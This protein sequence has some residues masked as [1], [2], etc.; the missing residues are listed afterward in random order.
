MFSVIFNGIV[1]AKNVQKK[2]II[3]TIILKKKKKKLDSGFE[4][5][6]RRI[7]KLRIR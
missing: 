1:R 6:V 5:K 4:S 2:K 7:G 3:Q